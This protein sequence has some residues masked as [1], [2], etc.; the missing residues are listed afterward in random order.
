MSGT[1]TS[2][3]LSALAALAPILE[4]DVYLAGGVAVAL[5]VGHRTSVDLDL[6]VPRSFDPD[7]LFERITHAVGSARSIGRATG[8][9]DLEVD[10]VPVSV[11]SYRYPL[12]RPVHRVA[13]V[14]IPVASSEDLACMKLSAIGGRGAAKDFWDLDELLNRGVAGGG[15]ADLLA[16]YRQKFPADDIG[17]VVRA[18]AYFGDADAAPLPAGLT[19]ERWAILKRAWSERSLAL[20]S[21]L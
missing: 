21:T 14:A 5:D 15:L 10:G 20:P 7:G 17:H 12:L 9:L 16:L 6:F 2:S 13:R 8:T 18:L 3:Q 19:P 1:I 11:L 4:G